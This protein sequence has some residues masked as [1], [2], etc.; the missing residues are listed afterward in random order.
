MTRK[1]TSKR[2]IQ[3][4]MGAALLI[5]GS[6]V[7]VAYSAALAWRFNVALNSASL[8]S[9][10]FFGSVGLASLHVVRIVALDHAVLL[11]VA[12][13]ILVFTLRADCDADRNRSSAKTS[14]RGDRAR[15]TS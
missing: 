12:R 6:T 10:G 1:Q 13:R 4:I 7:L 9:L 14:S 15:Q 8:N 2:H 11:S 3:G 5:V